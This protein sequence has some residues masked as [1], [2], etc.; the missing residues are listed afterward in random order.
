MSIT[1]IPAS[2]HK[3]VIVQV[4]NLLQQTLAANSEAGVCFESRAASDI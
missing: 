1:M 4:R 2:Q 3:T